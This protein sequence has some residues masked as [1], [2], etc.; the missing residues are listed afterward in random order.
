MF[1]LSFSPLFLFSL[2]L[3]LSPPTRY[4]YWG[5]V[6]AGFDMA[7][8]KKLITQVQLLQFIVGLFLLTHGYTLGAYCIYAPLYDMSMLLLFGNFYYRS[9]VSQ[10]SPRIEKKD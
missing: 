9:Y 6:A 7:H 8:H 2:S 5:L 1:V 4:G 3:S 10:P